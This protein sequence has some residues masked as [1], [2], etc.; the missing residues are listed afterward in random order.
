MDGLKLGHLISVI[1]ST[2]AEQD[3]GM[4][5]PVMSAR[6]LELRLWMITASGVSKEVV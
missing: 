1:A 2:V 4:G 5:V 3:L 6:K